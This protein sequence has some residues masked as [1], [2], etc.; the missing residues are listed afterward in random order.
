M[1]W[2]MKRLSFGWRKRARAPR[3]VPGTA[4]PGH[5]HDPNL[6]GNERADERI[7][8][9]QPDGSIIREG[10]Q[11]IDGFR[12]VTYPQSQRTTLDPV[13]QASFDSFPASDPPPWGRE[14]DRPAIAHYGERPRVGRRSEPA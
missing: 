10:P 7:R 6:D 11:D 4:S 1:K 9:L 5:S 12:I 14:L 3:T 8:V 2:L 13:D